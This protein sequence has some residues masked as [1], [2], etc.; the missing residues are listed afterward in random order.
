MKVTVV[1]AVIRTSKGFVTM[2][3]AVAVGAE[4]APSSPQRYGFIP[5][6]EKAAVCGV[7]RA[8]KGFETMSATSWLSAMEGNAR[9]LSIAPKNALSIVTKNAQQ[10]QLCGPLNILPYS[11]P[12][13]VSVWTINGDTPNR[14]KLR[15]KFI[16]NPNCD[17]ISCILI[18]SDSLLGTWS[19]CDNLRRNH[20]LI[21]T[22]NQP[23]S[24]RGGREVEA[25]QTK[26]HNADTTSSTVMY[27]NEYTAFT[28]TKTTHNNNDANSSDNRHK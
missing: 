22:K 19:T 5:R 7:I 17:K 8:C 13:H 27:N 20:D 3:T 9:T 1:E 11:G 12:K 24:R 14:Q 28:N 18:S 21:L 23:R 6:V 4:G 25:S 2:S 26:R 16:K 10:Q 15:E